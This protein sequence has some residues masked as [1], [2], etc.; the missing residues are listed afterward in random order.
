MAATPGLAHRP[1]GLDASDRMAAPTLAALRT[2]PG[3]R[4]LVMRILIVEDEVSMARSLARGLA[5]EG[6]TVDVALDGQ[7]GWPGPRP[8]ATTPSSW[9]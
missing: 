4:L 1:H 8:R 5:T 6:Y 3:G 9:I 2:P 7:E